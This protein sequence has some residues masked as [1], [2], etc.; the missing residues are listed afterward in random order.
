MYLSSVLCL[1][2]SL[3]VLSSCNSVVSLSFLSST[4]LHPAYLMELKNIPSLSNPG[5]TFKYSKNG[6]SITVSVIV[7]QCKLAIDID[8]TNVYFVYTQAKRYQM[9]PLEQKI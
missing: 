3:C 6:S 2:R 5:K 1:T 8:V 4:L 7:K 9:F